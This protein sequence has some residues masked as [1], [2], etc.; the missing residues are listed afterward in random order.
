V[1]RRDEQS[2]RIEEVEVS[3]EISGDIGEE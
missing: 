1:N 3:K 2:E